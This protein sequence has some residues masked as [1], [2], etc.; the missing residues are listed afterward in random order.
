MKEKSEVAVV[1]Q[2]KAKAAVVGST[3]Q[4]MFIGAVND[5]AQRPLFMA[6]PVPPGYT[7]N[8]SQQEPILLR[9]VT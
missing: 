9:D 4:P 6:P 1:G 2:V 7:H 3:Y 8:I 5:E